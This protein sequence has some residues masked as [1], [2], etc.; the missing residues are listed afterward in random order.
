M[1]K[2]KLTKEEV[3]L[4][5]ELLVLNWSNAYIKRHDVLYGLPSFISNNYTSKD[6]KHTVT[7]LESLEAKGFLLTG[8][9]DVG[10]GRM[11][12]TFTPITKSGAYGYPADDFKDYSE[13]M[14][15]AVEVPSAV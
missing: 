11:V 5:N 7:T 4:Y 15:N 13:W 1:S 9:E 10:E 8:P 2:P 14:Q 3:S 12:T 6:F